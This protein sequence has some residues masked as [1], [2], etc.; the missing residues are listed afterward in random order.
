MPSSRS[1]KSKKPWQG[2][3][4]LGSQ[5]SLL[6]SSPLLSPSSSPSHKSPTSPLAGKSTTNSDG[7]CT[8]SSE[9][10]V[11]S[12]NSTPTTKFMNASSSSMFS[13]GSD[14]PCSSSG[15]SWRITT[16]STMSHVLPY[17]C[18]SCSSSKGIWLRAMRTSG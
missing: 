1:M 15:L 3:P 17:R 9:P 2:K 10:T 7:E 11:G 13:S 12:R 6:T 16:G 14:F 4:C 8:S 5:T 18:P